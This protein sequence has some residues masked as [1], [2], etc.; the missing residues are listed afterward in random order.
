MRRQ[1]LVERQSEALIRAH[2]DL[3]CGDWEVLDGEWVYVKKTVGL[4]VFVLLV[5]LWILFVLFFVIL[6]LGFLV[7]F[8]GFVQFALSSATN[9]PA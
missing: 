6:F 5:L 7:L 9:A 1:L 4:F 8:G 2:G 3:F